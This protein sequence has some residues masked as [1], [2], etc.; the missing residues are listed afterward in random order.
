[1]K[2]I[3]LLI[4][5][6]CISSLG[7]AQTF[8]FTPNNSGGFEN[9]GSFGINQW[10]SVNGAANQWAVGNGTVF[11]GV[12]AAYIG[13][14]TTF[15][16]TNTPA[17]NHFY[18]TGGSAIPAGVTDVRL[19]FRY[20]QPV[21]DAG[22][23]SFI[24][25]V[26][27]NA[28]PTPVAGATVNALHTRLYQNSA[29]A[30]PGFVEVGPIDL[31][32]FAGTTVRLVFTHVNNGAGNI[33]IPA[34]DSISLSYCNL[35]AITGTGIACPGTT[36]TLSHA[37]AAGAWTSSNTAI[38]TVTGGTTAT[39]TGVSA[40]TATMT[41]T[42]GTCI[43]T[44]VVTIN[45][46]PSAITGT[47]ST[48]ITGN[49]TLSS[50]TTGG[51]WASSTPANATISAAGVATGVAAG[52]STITYTAPVTGCFTTS[53]LTVNPSPTAFTVTGGGSFCA[54]GAGVAI[55][56]NSSV[57][58]VN[59]SLWDG[60]SIVATTAGTGAAISFGTFTTAVTYT[61]TA[62]SA[63]TTCSS[64]MTGSATITIATP[65]VPSVSI[66]APAT[67]ICA[68]ASATFTASPTNEGIT[69]FYQWYVNGAPTG[70]GVTYS[71]TP[72]TGDV[73]SVTLYPGGICAVPDSATDSYTV[74]ITPLSAPGVTISAAPSNPSCLGRTVT[75]SAVPSFGG[76]AP[77]YR[78]TKNGVNLATGSTYSFVPVNGDVVYCMLTSNYVC[79]SADTVLSSTI[80]MTV[81]PSAPLPVVEILATPG[82][83]VTAGTDITLMA[84]VSGTSVPVNYQWVLNGVAIAGATSVS[85]TSGM[86]ANGDIVT[87]KVT[88][89]DPCANFTLKSVL[90][91][92]FPAGVGTHTINSAPFV[93]VPNPTT[94]NFTLQGHATEAVSLSVVNILGQVVYTTTA[95]PVNGT[96]S[97]P[98]SLQHLPV[99]TY[100]MHITS[101]Q[102]HQSIHF[103]IVK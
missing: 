72:T 67:T 87:C 77:A 4:L 68:G 71:Y 75:F 39:I 60:A 12:R 59:Y 74:V 52:L 103:N 78:W 93:I 61:A 81:V 85:Y 37:T 38:A 35:P 40:G 90:V 66:I 70:T 101:A 18:R 25:S 31:T 29:T 10:T 21:V 95:A 32:S 26:T 20:R 16:G 19:Y 1:M 23:D 48:C 94:G 11:A 84:A 2:K 65:V 53:V 15:V 8:I 99:G 46:V 42:V 96:I 82:L 100:I 98:C 54:S 34:V 33:G 58:G 57:I 62:T 27:N 83:T 73:V 13:N 56:L 55:G 3:Y 79:R 86:Y 102:N 97:Q 7:F 43:A 88:N 69:P 24:V 30:F 28:N 6:C 45:P 49:T 91:N 76:T 51:T 80:T 5:A 92:V 22:N 9:G 41:Y 44:R 89:E 36:T 14:A 64:D 50:A 63:I 47:L 17:I